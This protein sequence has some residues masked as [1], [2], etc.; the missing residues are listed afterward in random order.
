MRHRE[1]TLKP[2]QDTAE[3]LGKVLW[4]QRRTNGDD[5]I[6]RGYRKPHPHIALEV[7]RNGKARVVRLSVPELADVA[8][9]LLRAPRALCGAGFKG[10]A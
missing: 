7:W 6:L 10:A 4:Q 1:V 3:A 5:L 8:T 9:A 2:G